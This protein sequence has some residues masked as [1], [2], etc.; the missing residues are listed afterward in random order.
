[1]SEKRVLVSGGAGFIGSA[2]VRALLLEG[3]QVRV[4]D[5]LLPQVHGSNPEHSTS[6]RSI[7]SEIDFVHG[8]VRDFN[9]WN[10]ALEGQ[11]AVIHLA[12]LTG[13]GQSM[14]QA[15]EYTAVND[16]GT[17]AL[18]E[19]LTER[20]HAPS[21]VVVASS[22]AVYGEGSYRRPSDGRIVHPLPRASADLEMGHFA[23]RCPH[24]GEAL[25]P[26]PTAEDSPLSP[27]SVYAVTKLAQ[28][29]LVLSVCG[30]L[31]ITATA[32]RY[33]NVFGGGQSLQNPYTGILSIFWRAIREEQTI[34]VFEDGHAARD[35]VHISD[36]VRANMAAVSR[37]TGAS[38][39]VNVGTGVA[40]TVLD[41][42][43]A[44]QRHLGREARYEVSGDFRLG[45][46]RHCV[47]DTRRM[48][49]L[50]GIEAT[51]SFDEGC[52]EFVA[53]AEQNAGDSAP[54]A[55]YAQ[56]LDELRSRGLMR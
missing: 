53:W 20:R 21:H 35:F 16:G 51:L 7:R 31:G 27:A 54:T 15:R 30:A 19:C 25:E 11:H 41:A 18:L 45:D 39:I 26:I 46:I 3:W 10:Q 55:T 49:D 1:M 28:E 34:N 9:I 14:Y 47:A 17:A 8:D 22:R 5:N 43:H 50:L 24:T 48:H 36:T 52:R 4:L 37:A 42:L 56:S 40:T 2:T 12:A 29:Q 13:T 44:L 38:S 23:P 32:L 6:F 33:Q